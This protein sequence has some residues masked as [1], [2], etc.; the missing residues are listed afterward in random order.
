MAVNGTEHHGE[1]QG[2]AQLQPGQGQQVEP[3]GEPYGTGLSGQHQVRMKVSRQRFWRVAEA[4]Y[5]G[6]HELSDERSRRIGGSITKQRGA[7][8]TCGKGP[9]GQK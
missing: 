7:G 6:E 9:S 3:I 4:I 8:K 2:H 1:T 5:G